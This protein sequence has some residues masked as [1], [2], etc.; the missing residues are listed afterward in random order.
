[1]DDKEAEAF[2]RNVQREN[3]LSTCA[4]CD[5]RMPVCIGR[6]ED[7]GP[8][9]LACNE[10]CGHGNEDG[11]CQPIAVY[12]DNLR[13]KENRHDKRMKKLAKAVEL[14]QGKLDAIRLDVLAEDVETPQPGARQG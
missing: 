1:M 10:C 4:H 8:P 2:V 6:Y 7:S 13:R 5:E 12:Y 14:L 9:E 3:E 11:W